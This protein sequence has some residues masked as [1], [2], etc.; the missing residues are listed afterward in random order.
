MKLLSASLLA[1]LLSF[2]VVG[3]GG[4]TPSSESPPAPDA[5]AAP[6]SEPSASPAAAPA[7]SSSAKADAP[8][9]PPAEKPLT[10]A[11][12][13]QIITIANVGEVEQAK[14][15]TAK[16]KDAKVKKLASMIA[17]H[18]GESA[19]ASEKIAQKAKITPASS[20]LSDKLTSDGK[21]AT[22]AFKDLKGA[23]FDKAYIDAQ[24]AQHQALIALFDAKLL[25]AVQNADLKKEL[26][27]VRP[28]LEAHLKEAQSI[29]DALAAAPA[30]PAAPPAKDAKA[31]P[32]AKK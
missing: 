28:K 8:P 29:K 22:D 10:D 21:A 6:S 13:A 14:L 17:Q 20:A 25:S 30:A 15:A 31:A 9:P 1:S 4:S 18:H 23:D 16:A 7:S 12:I 26:E 3:C 5:A 27:S 11:E 19:K 24:V 32:P 2:S